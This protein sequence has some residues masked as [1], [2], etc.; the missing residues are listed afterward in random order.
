MK[1]RFD[2]DE[3]QRRLAAS[4][5]ASVLRQARREVT[6]PPGKALNI[7]VI[8]PSGRQ[9]WPVKFCMSVISLL[10]YTFGNP[11]SVPMAMNIM[12]RQ[13]SILISNRETLVHE[14]LD[15]GATHL[16]F[17]DDDHVFPA[18]AL[19]WLFRHNEPIV[20]TNYVRRT[21][22]VYP[23]AFAAD[24]EDPDA[25]GHFLY[26]KP[27]DKG[28]VEVASTGF[29]VGLVN[30]DVFR[31]IEEPWFDMQWRKNASG[32]WVVDPAE[33]IYFCRKARAA[34]Y[35]VYVDQELSNMVSHIGE[36]EFTNIMA[37]ELTEEALD[38]IKSNLPEQGA[39]Q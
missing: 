9:V 31:N 32:K 4:V 20:F 21:F 26:T 8:I 5:P 14:A 12:S 2:P 27:G 34:G 1:K 16:M 33:D 29:G 11:I 24:S 7:Q 13:G 35:K 39:V 6:P 37:Q 15:Q 18:H 30:A 22:P 38:Y 36:F 28:L 23:V 19:H 10:S 17:L 25:R 3:L